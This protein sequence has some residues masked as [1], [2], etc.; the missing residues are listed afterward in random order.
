MNYFVQI[1][2]KVVMYRNEPLDSYVYGY[3]NRNSFRYEQTPSIFH[4]FLIPAATVGD[5]YYMEYSTPMYTE[6][7]EHCVDKHQ[8]CT[9][10]SA[11]K[12]HFNSGRLSDVLGQ[13]HVLVQT[14]EEF[15]TQT[16]NTIFLVK[17]MFSLYVLLLVYQWYLQYFKF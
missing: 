10:C 12:Y 16:E 14:S 1:I 11:D 6:K 5:K 9:G 15:V 4:T 13:S 3:N 7:I 2:L 8:N 17:L